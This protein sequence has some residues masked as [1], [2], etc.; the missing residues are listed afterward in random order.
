MKWFFVDPSMNNIECSEVAW[1]EFS[2]Y[3]QLD[4]ISDVGNGISIKTRYCGKEHRV[5]ETAVLGLPDSDGY[6]TWVGSKDWASAMRRHKM[7]VGEFGTAAEIEEK[8]E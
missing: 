1:K 8:V 6:V 2:A 5:F 7:L 4:T 3:A